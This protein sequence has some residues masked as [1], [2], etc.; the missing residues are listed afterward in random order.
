MERRGRTSTIVSS[1]HL[2]TTLQVTHAIDVHFGNSWVEWE[3]VSNADA[4][5]ARDREEAFAE[6]P[7]SVGKKWRCAHCLEMPYEPDK[8][9]YPE[10][11]KHLDSM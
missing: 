6:Q 10:M 1:L 9:T 8:M 4:S 3:M 11:Q 7:S 2:L 5:L